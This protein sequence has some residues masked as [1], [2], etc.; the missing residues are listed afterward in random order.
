MISK[1]EKDI[2]EAVNKNG[3]YSHNLIS[4]TLRLIAKEKGTKSANALVDKY[5]LTEIYG[6]EKVD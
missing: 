5:R 6:I 3:P 2:R 1:H 4:A